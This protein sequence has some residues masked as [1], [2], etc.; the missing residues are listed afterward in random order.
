LV[1]VSKHLGQKSHQIKRPSSVRKPFDREISGK[2]GGKEEEEGKDTARSIDFESAS[3]C[4]CSCYQLPSP[5]TDL[6]QRY[7]IRNNHL[8]HSDIQSPRQSVMFEEQSPG[9]STGNRPIRTTI[10]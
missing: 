2:Y 3:I 7:S 1:R 4:S 5:E 8:E 10:C 9:A 6:R